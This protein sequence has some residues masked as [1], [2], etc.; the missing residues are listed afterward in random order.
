MNHVTSTTP[1]S[2]NSSVD[3]YQQFAQLLHVYHR[4][5]TARHQNQHHLAVTELLMHDK[6]SA[7]VP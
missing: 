7:L 6:C 1:I 3:F 2:C 5:E 4:R